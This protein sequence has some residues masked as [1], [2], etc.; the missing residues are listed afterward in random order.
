[1]M[2]RAW[3]SDTHGKVLCGWGADD[4]DA[5][6]QLMHLGR[7][8]GRNILRSKTFCD[9]GGVTSCAT[10]GAWWRLLMQLH[11]FG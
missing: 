3:V 1:M 2:L 9:V 10:K 7:A 4:T 5:G 8:L 6:K 11:G